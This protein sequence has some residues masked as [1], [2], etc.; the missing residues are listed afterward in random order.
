MSNQNALDIT[1]LVNKDCFFVTITFCISAKDSVLPSVISKESFRTSR[2]PSSAF[3]YS[4]SSKPSSTYKAS[5]VIMISIVKIIN[6]LVKITSR[7]AIFTSNCFISRFRSAA[8]F[9]TRKI[10]TDSYRT[11]GEEIS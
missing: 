5:D 9:L 1:S 8:R 2:T 4:T 10:R 11:T 7:N 6:F 3:L